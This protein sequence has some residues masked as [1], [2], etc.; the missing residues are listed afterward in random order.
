M[1]N[2]VICEAEFVKGSRL[3]LTNGGQTKWV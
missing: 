1:R 3:L 2:V